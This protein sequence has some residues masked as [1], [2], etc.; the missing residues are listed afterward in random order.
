MSMTVFAILAGRAINRHA[1][2]RIHVER[3]SDWQHTDVYR[4]CAEYLQ[5]GWRGCWQGSNMT[6][7]VLSCHWRLT[8]QEKLL[9]FHCHM[10]WIRALLLLVTVRRCL[11][12]FIAFNI[13]Q[14]IK[15][16]HIMPSVLP[17]NW[18][19]VFCVTILCFT[20]FSSGVIII[21]H[22]GHEDIPAIQ[23]QGCPWLRLYCFFDSADTGVNTHPAL[24]KHVL[25][26]VFMLNE[27]SW[28]VCRVCCI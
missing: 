21:C 4:Y 9:R 11:S 20:S 24:F 5:S 14:Y 16:N 10:V 13:S 23:T 15:K 28:V 26:F 18:Y 19:S 1:K 7:C 22:V 3:S 17:D 2:D 12:T 27:C 6:V 25:W 8:A